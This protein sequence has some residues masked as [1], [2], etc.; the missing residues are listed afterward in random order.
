LHFLN[1]SLM[2]C[3]KG[4]NVPHKSRLCPR[5]GRCIL[6]EGEQST[7]G[8]GLCYISFE[9]ASQITISA[10]HTRTI[11]IL[12]AAF[13]NS[14]SLIF[15]RH[16]PSPHSPESLYCGGRLLAVST[17]TLLLL[18]RFLN[19]STTSSR[20]RKRVLH[21]PLLSP[22]SGPACTTPRP[23]KSTSIVHDTLPREIL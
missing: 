18:H 7:L 19:G 22:P 23:E 4:S 16:L 10:H 1:L 2:T 12:S 6:L 14:K 8:R 20:T 15:M 11:S 3:G 9:A 21:F 13:T 17:L 5:E